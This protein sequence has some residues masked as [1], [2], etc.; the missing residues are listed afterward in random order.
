MHSKN[1]EASGNEY[2]VL[3]GVV[4][5]IQVAQ[6]TQ[7]LLE[8]INRHYREQN[9]LLSIAATAFELYGQAANAATVAMYSGEDTENFL[10]LLDNQVMCGTFAGASKL[11][12]GEKV[13]VIATRHDD[14]L[15]ARAILSEHRGYLWINGEPV[16]HSAMRRSNIKWAFYAGVVWCGGGGA[17]IAGMLL[18]FGS[19]RFFELMT[20][21]SVAILCIAF[22]VMLWPVGDGGKINTRLFG[23]LGFQNPGRVNLNKYRYSILHIHECVKNSE[24]SASN[25]DVYCYKNAIEDGKLHIAAIP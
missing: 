22:P 20:I 2:I 6:G 17:V 23:L 25:A 15:V 3:E 18:G 7:N 1:N 19:D 9:T 12:E 24:L 21:V 16:G 4:R 13:K 8:K 14:I 10:C 5:E 11:S